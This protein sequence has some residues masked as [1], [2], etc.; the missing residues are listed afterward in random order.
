MSKKGKNFSGNNASGKRKKSDFYE[1]PYSITRH[2]LNVEDFDYNLT[3]C[4]PACGDGAIVKVLQEKTNNV[5]FYD[6]EKNF[7]TETEQYDYIVTNPPFSIAYEFIQK[8]KIVTKKKFAF[9][10]PLSYLHGKK[11]YDD[12]YSDKEYPLKKVYVFTRYPMLGEQLRE[13]GKYNTG[14]MVYAW[15]IFEKDYNGPSVVDWID[16][17]SDVLSKN[18]KLD[19]GLGKLQFDIDD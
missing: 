19:I 12:I 2:L 6:I 18:D 9:L 11:R 10:L 3:I 16:N 14:M 8:A 13:D 4:E 17:N 5:V 1:T 15:F 7:L